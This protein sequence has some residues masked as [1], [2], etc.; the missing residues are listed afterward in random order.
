MIPGYVMHDK[1]ACIS[2]DDSSL[3]LT[4][5]YLAD[6]YVNTE[7]CDILQYIRN[8]GAKL[9][10]NPKYGYI[11]KPVIGKYGWEDMQE[12][13][14]ERRPLEKYRKEIIGL[15]AKL[16]QMQRNR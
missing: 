15:L 9:I 8:T 7:L 10:R 11:I 13:E 16:A 2:P 3:W 6:K 4:L 1:Y 5:F 12:Y 14:R